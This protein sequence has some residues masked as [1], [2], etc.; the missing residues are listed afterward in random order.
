MAASMYADLP[1]SFL[2]WRNALSCSYASRI[3]T[4]F[5]CV[6]CQYRSALRCSWGV[7]RIIRIICFYSVIFFWYAT[8][9][10]NY[11][12]QMSSFFTLDDFDDWKKRVMR[13]INRKHSRIHAIVD[14]GCLPI[15]SLRQNKWFGVT[16]SLRYANQRVP[17]NVERVVRF[18]WMLE[19]LLTSGRFMVPKKRHT[20]CLQDGRAFQL[21][22]FTKALFVKTHVHA[23][24]NAMYDHL[25]L[26]NLYPR[27][28]P[29]P[30]VRGGDLLHA[31]GILFTLMNV[32]FMTV[33]EGEDLNRTIQDHARLSREDYFYYNK[34]IITMPF[35]ATLIEAPEDA[36][37]DD[38]MFA[39]CLETYSKRKQ[40]DRSAGWWLWDKHRDT[41]SST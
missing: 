16:A 30:W 41:E 5:S 2:R 27:D 11:F 22:Y 25:H 1:P 7:S 21:E 4:A 24:D 26:N 23:Q 14:R 36:R 35:P 40:S 39:T 34:R 31:C 20:Y 28:A 12:S 3:L 33:G 29:D 8:H 10:S 13:L 32:R 19:D 17:T 15:F 38:E 9:T 6:A 18:R 37:E